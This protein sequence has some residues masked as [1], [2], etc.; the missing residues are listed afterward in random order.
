MSRGKMV[1]G[2]VWTRLVGAWELGWAGLG[3]VHGLGSIF[4]WRFL[5]GGEAPSGWVL[6]QCA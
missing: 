2:S 5:A 3:L 6:I 4:I 1:V